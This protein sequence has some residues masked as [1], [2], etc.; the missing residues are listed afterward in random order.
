[1]T[2]FLSAE[3]I[4]QLD[5]ALR[6]APN[7]DGGPFVLEQVVNEVPRRGVVRYRLV[8]ADGTARVSRESDAPVDVRLTTDYETAVA[9]ARGDANAQVALSQGRL[10][11]TG[12]SEALTRHADELRQLATAGAELRPTTTFPRVIGSARDVG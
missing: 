9:I 5:A 10:R 8:V 7:L 3:W 2:E 12:D 11:I 6:A 1:M 4:D